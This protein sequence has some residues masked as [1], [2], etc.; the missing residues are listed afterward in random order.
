MG[1]S[2]ADVQLELGK[3]MNMEMLKGIVNPEFKLHRLSAH[4]D[5]DG[6]F[7]DIF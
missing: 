1:D 2:P 4:P 3:A 7:D 5:V 6:G